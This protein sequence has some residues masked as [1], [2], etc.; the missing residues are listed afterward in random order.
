MKIRN[1]II[2]YFASAPTNKHKSRVFRAPVSMNSETALKLLKDQLDG[3]FDAKHLLHVCFDADSKRLYVI[4]KSYFT[5]DQFEFLLSEI[6]KKITKSF[7]GYSDEPI[8]YGSPFSSLRVRYLDCFK[9]IKDTVDKELSGQGIEDIPI[10][11]VNLNRMPSVLK[12]LPERHKQGM[13]LGGY[14]SPS[15]VKG[16]HF[17]EEIDVKGKK[18]TPEK[19]LSQETPFIFINIGSDPS[20]PEKEW[21]V[22]NGYREYF[23]DKSIFGEK[24]DEK[25]SDAFLFAIKRFLKL[26]WTFEEVCDI[27]TKGTSD[28]FELIG[29]ANE[30]MRIANSF[31]KDGFDNPST[32]PYYTTFKI[33]EKFPIN[34]E[35]M[36]QDGSFTPDRQIPWFRIIDFNKRTKYVVIETPIFVREEIW[37]KIFKPVNSP[38]ITRYNAYTKTIDV[39]SSGHSY[40]SLEKG[41]R[42]KKAQLAKIQYFVDASSQIP[43]RSD[44]NSRSAKTGDGDSFHLRGMTDYHDACNQ[45]R[46]LAKKRKMKFENLNVV[47]GPLERI[48]GA[49]TR[50]GFMDEE[51]FKK[52]ELEIPY[53]ITKGI[54][55]E[56][57]LITIDSIEMPSPAE[58][59]ST[60]VHEYS[61]NLFHIQNPEYENLY[62]KDPKLKETDRDKY[63]Y[64]YLTDEDERQAHG[65][66]VKFEIKS[67]KSVDEMIRD[68]VGGQVTPDTYNVAILFKDIIDSV[69]EEME[70]ENE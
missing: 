33:D 35:S 1:Q 50:G 38:L 43:F 57:P 40:S 46:K 14:I 28:L 47:V 8:I 29:S 54:F 7:G 70:N 58:Q 24:A 2:S 52:S 59:A 17:Y 42:D 5:K 36:I 55:V 39:K 4:N 62:H 67:G 34:I 12:A 3:D 30:L 19:L 21:H 22:L 69:L 41:E 45:L 65:E 64:L 15:D 20:S 51:C 37:R 23:R 48:F 56:P 26:G 49:G 44:V 63:W 53:E 61:H 27:F 6:K 60:L 68:K 66:Q 16:M 13:I 25:H 11:E 31:E 10:I 32:T 9:Y 18:K